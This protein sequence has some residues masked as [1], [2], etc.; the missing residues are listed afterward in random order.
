M[1]EAKLAALSAHH[2]TCRRIRGLLA[3]HPALGWTGAAEK[4][5]TM[6]TAETGQLVEPLPAPPVAIVGKALSIAPGPSPFDAV[7]PAPAGPEFPKW[8]LKGSKVRMV[9]TGPTQRV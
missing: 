3:K 7:Y 5:A 8:E 6:L 1:N 9:W 2:R 4:V